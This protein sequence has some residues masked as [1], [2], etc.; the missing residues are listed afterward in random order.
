MATAHTA[1]P[2]GNPLLSLTKVFNPLVLLLAGTRLLPLYG[3]LTHCGRRSGTT[4]RTPVVVRPTPDGFVIPMPWGERTDWYRNIRAAGG[5]QVRWKG[6]DYPLVDPEVLDTSA[7][8]SSFSG[9][10]ARMMK[11]LHI[12]Q[13]LHV[14]HQQ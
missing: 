1:R 10:Q 8:G 14:R 13:V 2:R 9:F 11:R 4:F 3:V 12:N 7:A 6:R 5:G